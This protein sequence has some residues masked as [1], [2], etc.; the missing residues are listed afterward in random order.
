MD[1]IVEQAMAK[2]PNVPDCYGWLWLDARGN[3]YMRDDQ[4]QAAG[5][6][7]SGQP[8][9]KGSL[10]QHDKLIDFIG[11]NYSADALGRWF[12]QNGPQRVF[13]EL[14]MAPLVWR[15][16]PD[17]SVKDHIG[18]Q[19]TVHSSWLDEQGHLFLAA[20]RGFGLVH[21][22]DMGLAADAVE[23]GVWLPQAVLN[24]DLPIKFGFVRS[25]ASLQNK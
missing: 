15:V 7:D 24:Q 21:T 12:F 20:D 8:G 14:Q 4:A 9:S 18:R 17:L 2:W 11:R 23:R 3:W 10:L 1:D 6:F 5:A 25:P 19:A 13:I 16:Q 22:Q